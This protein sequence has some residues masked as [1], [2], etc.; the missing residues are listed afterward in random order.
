MKKKFSLLIIS[1][2]LCFNYISAASV[3]DRVTITTGQHTIIGQHWV[4]ASGEEYT[5]VNNDIV[6]QSET[7]TGLSAAQDACRRA[8]GSSDPDACVYTMQTIKSKCTLDNVSNMVPDQCR[9]HK[10]TGTCR[11]DSQDRSYKCNMNGE[12]YESYSQCVN[13]CESSCNNY[14]ATDQVNTI[15]KI[16]VK[17]GSSNYTGSFTD[18][19]KD[20]IVYEYKLNTGDRAYCIQPGRKGPTGDLYCLNKEMNLKDCDDKLQNHYYCGLAQIL[21]YTM[22]PTTDSN[23][24]TTFTSNDAE[25]GFGAITAALRMWVSYYGSMKGNPISGIDGV[26]F[27]HEF[28]YFTNT[29][30]YLSTAKAAAGGYTGEA[31]W[32]AKSDSNLGVL[33]GIMSGNN[34]Y[35]VAIPLFNKALAMFNGNSSEKFLDGMLGT[36]DDKFQIDAS[37]RDNGGAGMVAKWPTS[38]VEQ[39]ER[40]TTTSS[41]EIQCSLDQ[42][43]RKDSRCRMYV[44]VFYTDANGI[45]RTVPSDSLSLVG[46]ACS[47]EKCELEVGGSMTCNQTETTESSMKK[48]TFEVTLKGYNSVGLIREYRHCTNPGVYQIMYTAAF[49]KA[50]SEESGPESSTEKKFEK[51]VY[52]DCPC[53]D[54]TKCTD[55]NPVSKTLSGDL[56]QATCGNNYDSYDTFDKSDPYMNCI[57]H[58]C[59]ESDKL[60]FRKTEEVGANKNVCDVYCRREVVFYLANK[61]K[62]YAGM[63]FRYDIGPAVRSCEQT[64]T[65]IVRTD[66]ALT[67]IVLQKQQCTSEIYYDTKNKY[68]NKKSW[69]DQ[70]AEAVANMI[71]AWN[72]W[73]KIEVLYNWE[74][75]T[76]GNDSGGSHGKKIEA[77]AKATYTGG[78]GTCGSNS[79]STDSTACSKK[80]L[81]VWPGKTYTSDAL[82]EDTISAD[83]LYYDTWTLN[84]S[85]TPI[86]GGG[87]KCPSKLL[88]SGNGSSFIS[89]DTNT[90]PGDDDCG[91]TE[92]DCDENGDNCTDSYST[93]NACED[94]YDYSSD[95][96]YNKSS[97]SDWESRLFNAYKSALV[98]I[99]QLV[100]DLQNCNFF[101]SSD[102]SNSE[103]DKIKEIEDYKS[104]D[105]KYHIGENNA[106]S[107]VN[108]AF[109]KSSKEYLLS[110]A[111][112]NDAN[113]DCAD[114]TV[115]YEDELYGK[116]VTIEK[117]S[118]IVK[119]DLNKNYYCRNTNDNNPNCY[120]YVKGDANEPNANGNI[121]STYADHDYLVCSGIKNGTCVSKTISLPTNDYST[122][123]TVTETDFWRSDKFSAG[124]YTGLVGEA[125]RDGLTTPLGNEEYPVSNGLNTGGKTGNYTVKQHIDNVKIVVDDNVSLDYT[126]SYDVYNTTNLYDCATRTSNGKLDLS[127]CKNSCYKLVAGV[128]VITKECNEFELKDNESKGYGFVYRNIDLTNVFPN[129]V[130]SD[131]DDPNTTKNNRPI[132]TNWA[133]TLG[134]NVKTQIEQK[135]DD[136]FADESNLKYSFILTP[137]AISRI[138]EYNTQ[139]ELMGVGYQDNSYLS[140]QLVNDPSGLNGFYKCKSSFLEEISQPNNSYDVETV[141]F[142]NP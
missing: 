30:V 22:I 93:T 25:Y 43:L 50:K 81:Y 98:E 110:K 132:G 12:L 47:K 15:Y 58:P 14:C 21:Y 80:T 131:Q 114:L 134:E 82:G 136:M 7:Y 109:G 124:A 142:S 59:K 9:A 71:T 79:C 122:F 101:V 29:K 103:F 104:F 33:C 94:G 56:G 135:G 73:K 55:F 123:I 8:T 137:T 139:Q 89:G 34:N 115:E 68:G 60:Q 18:Q 3:N 83:E 99:S 10:A 5:N 130:T 13:Y 72:N 74:K 100:Y 65:E 24:K 76:Y 107:G 6:M 64:V 126:C 53:N 90:G 66:V 128:P 127:A 39:Y 37:K 62:V 70:Y 112:C 38:F 44:Q 78:S 16:G 63:Q 51:S 88:S 141:K 4:S 84:N 111:L 125:G 41:Y 36:S 85:C 52:S 120:K 69:Q 20:S 1:L 118:K 57:L 87:I 75:T 77:I 26:G 2:L 116:N 54:D 133:T 27:E 92:C 28:D 23:G 97:M 108:K 31:C 19:L 32:Q 102:N 129:S 91:S 106:V 117:E 11:Y 40:E 46:G 113:S 96:T 49:E 140:C 42:L 35:S 61:K 119:S 95:P 67:S 105:A 48:Y 121:E 138:R 45:K 17:G 86:N